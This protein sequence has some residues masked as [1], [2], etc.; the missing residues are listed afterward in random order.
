MVAPTPV[1]KE[2]A[3]LTATLLSPE[4]ESTPLP[5]R[6]HQ[7]KFT[8][9]DGKTDPYMHVSHYRQ[10]MAGH[11]R[12]DTLM[13]LIFPASL[14]ELGL[15]WF[16]RLPEGSIEGWQQLVEAFITRF[17][18]NTRT[19]KEVDR[20]LG[21]KMESG[22]SLKAY[23]ARYL[24]TYNKIHD[25]PTNLAITQY[26]RGLPVGHRLRH[27]L[28]MH[29]PTTM[30]SLLQRI[31]E[32]IR[33][34]DDAVSAT[35][36]AY[37]IVEDRKVAGKVHSIGQE[38]NRPNDRS[39]DQCRGSNRDDRNKGRRNDRADAPRDAKED[40]KRKLKARTGIT[41]GQTEPNGMA[42]LEAAPQGVINVIHGIIEPVRVC[43]LRGM[44]KK[45]EHMREV[46]SDQ[47]AVK[48]GK[49]EEKDILTFSRRDLERIQMPHNDAL[50]VTLHVKDFDIKRFLIDQESSVK[51]MYYDTFKQMKL[52]DKDLAPAT[53]PLVG[54]NSQPEW[55]V[56]KIILPVKAGSVIKQVELWVLKVP[57]TY[58]LILGRW[59]LYA[60]QA[61]VS[62]YY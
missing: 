22:G 15:K 11:R 59:W 37:P 27:W 6:F 45:A 34:N 46:L 13:C 19:P 57:S 30:E 9:Y 51:I 20:L 18:T 10:V 16:E 28:T 36:K 47:P 3:R 17:K 52:E 21:V 42:A 35:E 62:T 60:M 44:I 53:S 56:G 40:A 58:N 4:I 7:P 14:G 23:N 33:V 5:A 25:C 48:K 54:F 39:K 49:T 12:N 38:D 24:E 29:Q 50:V 32:Q 55:S 41:T 31:N 61:V 2:L 8:L 1:D 26:N 43:E